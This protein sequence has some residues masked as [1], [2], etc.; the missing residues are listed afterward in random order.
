MFDRALKQMRELIRAR[1][2]IM[3]VHAEEEMD[4]DDLSIYDIESAILTGKIIK[5]QRDRATDEWKY[6]V[7]G[8][9]IAGDAVTV[10]AK[11][12]PTGK[13]ILIT[14]FRE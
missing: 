1:Q 3:P 14:V 5:R 7:G 9:S 10:V 8:Q 6:L 4:A 11:F 12:S 2:Y 13:L